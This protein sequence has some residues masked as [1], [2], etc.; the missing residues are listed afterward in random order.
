MSLT[1]GAAAGAAAAGAAAAGAGTAAFWAAGVVAAPFCVAAGA[2][3]AA[4][5]AGAAG[6]FAAAGAAA[7]AAGTA[8]AA[9]FCAAYEDDAKQAIKHSRAA[10]AVLTT[11]LLVLLRF[12]FLSPTFNAKPF[13]SNSTPLTI[14]RHAIS[15]AENC[16]TN[17]WRDFTQP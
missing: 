13:V 9:A 2:G 7:F 1:D 15:T 4:L 16:I 3:A 12:I 17:Q 6:F 14:T 5:G 8:E 11:G 10:D